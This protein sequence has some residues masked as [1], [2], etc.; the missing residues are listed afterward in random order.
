[1]R[2]SRNSAGQYTKSVEAKATVAE[3]NAIALSR[4]RPAIAVA[5][6]AFWLSVLA[7]LVS[8]LAFTLAVRR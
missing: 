4:A 8:A 7:V 5:K 6:F 3:A 1:M 2:V